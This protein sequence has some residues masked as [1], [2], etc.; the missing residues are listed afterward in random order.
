MAPTRPGL[1]M[2]A[3]GLTISDVQA[4]VSALSSAITAL[5]VLIGGLW[6]YFKFVRGRT[7]RPR[8]SVTMSAQWHPLNGRPMLHARITV[9]NIGA[10]IVTLRQRGGTGLGI[11]VLSSDQPAPPAAAEWE[12]IRVFEILRDH[13]WIEPGETVSD[14]LLLDLDSDEPEVLLFEARLAWSWSGHKREIV[15]MARQVFPSDTTLS[16]ATTAVSD[17]PH[18]KGETK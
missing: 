5:A 9:K 7:Y 13:E 11:G 12:V 18:N 14:D 8:L 17:G 2:H 6:A 16:G 4:V 15:V 10:S 1:T 3:E